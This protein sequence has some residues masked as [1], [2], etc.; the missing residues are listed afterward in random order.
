MTNDVVNVTSNLPT[1]HEAEVN[2]LLDATRD[3]F[4]KLLKFKKGKFYIQDDE[5]RIGAEYVAHPSK[6]TLCWIKFS[7]GEVADRRFGKAAEGY[8]PPEREELGDRDES[9]WERGL[10]GKPK[11]PW[12]F[13]HL[14]PLENPEN[15]EVVIFTTSS[16]GGEIGVKELVRE[17]A[18][19]AKKGSRALPIVKLATMDMNTKKYGAVPRPYFPV[20]AWD[21]L[22]ADNVEVSIAA[23]A[24]LCADDDMDDS[25]PF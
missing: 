3:V 14:L 19:R 18:R 1:T 6:L 9:K 15:G 12:S 11:D 22:P 16:V 5:V 21:A 2:N 7:G 13:Q 4:Q 23:A 8:R 25:I 10:D 17:W 20:I 24:A